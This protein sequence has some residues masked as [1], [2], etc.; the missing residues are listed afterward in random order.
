MLTRTL[1][2][3]IAAAVLLAMSGCFGPRAWVITRTPQGGVIGYQNRGSIFMDDRER[4]IAFDKA[5]DEATTEVCGQRRY[6]M[7]WDRYQ[8]EQ[9]SYTTTRTVE[10]KS[11]TKFDISGYAR[12][13]VSATGRAQTTTTRNVPVTENYTVSWREMAIACGSQQYGQVPY[14]RTEVVK[15]SGQAP[16]PAT[17]SHDARSSCTSADIAEMQAARLSESAIES[18][19]GPPI[20]NAEPQV[21]ARTL[22]DSDIEETIRLE[23]DAFARCGAEQRRLDGS[24]GRLLIRFIVAAEGTVTEATIVAKEGTGTSSTSCWLDTAKQLRFPRRA[25]A[26]EAFRF[27]FKY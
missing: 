6:T 20:K 1:P 10:E 3:I 26:G 16:T 8:S 12:G 2:R 19:C 23:T 13:P 22:T 5:L 27:P 11:E 4:Q 7:L 18:A 9:R 25:E 15:R 17:G 24:G 21:A 14:E